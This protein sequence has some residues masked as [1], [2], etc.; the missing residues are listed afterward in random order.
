MATHK[1]TVEFIL[2]HLKPAQRFRA[3]AMFGEYA[4]Y[5]DDKVAALICNDLLHVKILPQSQALENKCEKAPP[6]PGA[7][8][9]YVVEEAGL[10]TIKNLSAIL[11]A[12]AAALPGKKKPARK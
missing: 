6:Y 7:K 12:I 3:Q 10:T 8:P 1:E 4:L 2:D 9:H 11:L 5:A